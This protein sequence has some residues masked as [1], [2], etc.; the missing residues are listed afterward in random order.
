MR[1]FMRK[2][3]LL[4]QS[5]TDKDLVELKDVEEVVTAMKQQ[6]KLDALS[7]FKMDAKYP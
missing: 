1:T 4:S 7:S 6:N 2:T 3:N 5:A